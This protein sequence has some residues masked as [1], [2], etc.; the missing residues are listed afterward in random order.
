M[1]VYSIES[2][3]FLAVNAAIPT[4]A[5]MSYGWRIPFLFSIAFVGVGIIIQLRMEDTS[6]FRRLQQE[7]QRRGQRGHQ[8]RER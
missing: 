7:R 1:W 3:K 2:Q 5:F 6:P 8:A 4:E